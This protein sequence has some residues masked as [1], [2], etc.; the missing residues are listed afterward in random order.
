VGWR[1]GTDGETL[2]WYADEALG[3][4]RDLLGKTQAELRS[5]HFWRDRDRLES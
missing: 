5:P 4:E 3:C 2:R 1:D